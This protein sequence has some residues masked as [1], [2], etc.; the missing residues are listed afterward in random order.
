M[1]D[2]DL[3]EKALKKIEE[4]NNLLCIYMKFHEDPF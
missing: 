2:I 4:I 3:K 1:K